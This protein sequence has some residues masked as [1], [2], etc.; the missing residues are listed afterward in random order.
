MKKIHIFAKHT[1]QK[2][3]D[4][5][6]T[7]ER[8]P[9]AD[10]AGALRGTAATGVILLHSIEHFNFRSSPGTAGQSEWLDFSDKAIWDG[11]SLPFG[12]KAYAVSAL[13]FDFILLA[14]MASF[15]P[16]PSFCKRRTRHHGHGPLEHVR[17]RGAWLK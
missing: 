12:G 15:I 1:R 6:S 13:P 4:M 11:M 9:R 16:Q 14:G 5:Q 10:V 7:M 2:G 8:Q 17:E 3:K